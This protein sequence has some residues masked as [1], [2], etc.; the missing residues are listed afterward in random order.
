MIAKCK[1]LVKILLILKVA[2]KI[3]NYLQ[4]R[5]LVLFSIL[6]FV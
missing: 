1:N 5:K 6:F 2:A 4:E 3:I